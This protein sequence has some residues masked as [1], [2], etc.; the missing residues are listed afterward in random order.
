MLIICFAFVIIL[1]FWLLV[2][3]T[4]HRKVT[5]FKSVI[6]FQYVSL[7]KFCSTTVPWSQVPSYAFV[8]EHGDACDT[9]DVTYALFYPFNYGKVEVNLQN[10]LPIHLKRWIPWSRDS[11]HLLLWFTH[12]CRQ[13]LHI[14][15][16]NCALTKRRL[17]WGLY[18]ATICWL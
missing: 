12:F 8:T 9:V 18:G 4:M 16:A 1:L 7:W 14:F 5:C 3:N 10:G 15:P 11:A 13:C 6:H 17:C 2:L